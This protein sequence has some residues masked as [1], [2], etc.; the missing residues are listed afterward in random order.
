MPKNAPKKSA[1]P[2]G[3]TNK[4]YSDVIGGYP[5]KKTV[6]EFEPK[7]KGRGQGSAPGSVRK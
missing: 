7:I 6:E 3:V 1:N 4:E 2:S 5:D